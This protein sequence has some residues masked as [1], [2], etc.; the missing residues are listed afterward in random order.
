MTDYY[1]NKDNYFKSDTE[2]KESI[3]EQVKQG[4]DRNALM[5]EKNISDTY[6]NGK[7][8]VITK[9]YALRKN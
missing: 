2:S 3:K 8:K 9:R 6:T 4:Y 7:T 5:S 1:E